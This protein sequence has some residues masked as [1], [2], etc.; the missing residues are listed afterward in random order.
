MPRWFWSR[1]KRNGIGHGDV[2]IE[3]P[4]ATAPVLDTTTGDMISGGRPLDRIEL[5]GEVVSGTSAGFVLPVQGNRASGPVQVDGS[6]AAFQCNPSSGRNAIPP[7]QC[8]RAGSE[9]VVRLCPRA[10]R[11]LVMLTEHLHSVQQLRFT[12]PRAPRS[13]S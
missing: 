8:R 1:K 11:S 7:D 9:C 5:E 10:G 4:V 3:G 6:T 12:T 13:G 2:E